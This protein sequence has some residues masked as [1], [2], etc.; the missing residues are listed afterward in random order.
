MYHSLEIEMTMFTFKSKLSLSKNTPTDLPEQIK[1]MT[2]EGI[3]Q[4]SILTDETNYPYI[5]KRID[6]LTVQDV[7]AGY[8]PPAQINPHDPKLVRHVKDIEIET[9]FLE[10]IMSRVIYHL[11]QGQIAVPE[12]YYHVDETLTPYTISKILPNFEEF[13]AKKECIKNGK[14]CFQPELPSRDQLKLTTEEAYIVGQLYAVALIVNHWDVLNSKMLNS[15]RLA[16]SNSTAAIVDL[17]FCAHLS[18]KGRHNDSLAFDDPTFSSSH[19]SQL[20][21]SGEVYLRHYRHRNALPFDQVISPLLPHTLIEDLYSMENSNTDKTS[22]AVKKGFITAINLAKESIS[23][24]PSIIYKAFAES[25]DRISEESSVNA[26]VLKKQFFST[27][28]YKP[29]PKQHNL[30]SIIKGRVLSCIKLVTS[31]ELGFTQCQL[32][33]QAKKLYQI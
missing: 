28:Y 1:S 22:L 18:Y 15:G 25:F 14:A 24:D 13:L 23:K 6:P 26:Q 4:K 11:F 3:T 9:C 21:F 7:F 10:I 19:T 12:L 5:M 16:K 27:S 30:F 8:L 31:L 20:N 32:H 2:T 17:G 29:I 33:D